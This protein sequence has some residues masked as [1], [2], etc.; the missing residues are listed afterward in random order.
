MPEAPKETWR[1]LPFGEAARRLGMK[2]GAARAAAVVRRKER[3][4]ER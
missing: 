4:E 2:A 1:I 3:R